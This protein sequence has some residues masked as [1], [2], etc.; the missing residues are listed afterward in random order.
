MTET[1]APYLTADEVLTVALRELALARQAERA[2]ER[3]SWD[4]DDELRASDAW[5]KAE[6]S[7]KA[8]REAAERTRAAEDRVARMLAGVGTTEL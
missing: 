8:W 5:R 1:E 6:A 7:T 2:A 4:D 3:A